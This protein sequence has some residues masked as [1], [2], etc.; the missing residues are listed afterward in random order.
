[1]TKEQARKILKEQGIVDDDAEKIIS[2]CCSDDSCDEI[3]V[4]SEIKNQK[5]SNHNIGDR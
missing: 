4:K 3:C 2:K 1:M 5:K